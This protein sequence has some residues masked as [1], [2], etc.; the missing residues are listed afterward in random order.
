MKPVSIDNNSII[1]DDLFDTSQ[2]FKNLLTIKDSI[3]YNNCNNLDITI[4]STINK[5]IVKNTNDAIIYVNKTI[6]GIDIINSNNIE[7]ITN[8][9]PIYYLLIKNSENI[10]IILNNKNF[11]DTEISIEDSIKI[12]FK[13]YNKKIFFKL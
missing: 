7:I 9:D 4:G 2:N 3:T 8:N 10:S 5:L 6:S 13:N 1:L 12:Y 11:K